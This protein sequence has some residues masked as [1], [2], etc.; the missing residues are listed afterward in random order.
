VSTKTGRVSRF[1][2]VAGVALAMA[3]T[4]GVLAAC[5]PPPSSGPSPTEKFCE[6]WDK[7]EEQQP[8]QDPTVLEDQAVLVKDEVVALADQ[9]EVLGNSCTDPTAR[10]DLDGAVLAEGTEVLEEQ[11]TASTDKVAAITGE[12]IAPGEPVLENVRLTA[13]SAEIGANG[14]VVRGNVAVQL[15]GTTSTIG[16]IGTLQSLE[17]WSVGL[18]STGFTLP[19]ITTSPVVFNG[20]LRV[21]GGVP[22]LSL[23]AQA[24]AVKIGDVSVTGASLNVQA[25]PS[26]GVQ[27]SVVGN[28]KVGP[29]TVSGTVD[30]DFD[31]NGALVSINADIAA[32]LQGTQA[33][34]KKIDL[35]GA[36]KIVGNADETAITFSG[37]G[38]L[39]DLV[40]NEANGSLVLA[41]NKATL[42]GVIDVQQ[43]PNVVR[44]NGSIVWD[45]ITAYTPFLTLQGAG[46]YSGTL[47]DGTELSVDGTLDTTVVGGQVRAV[48]E[49]NFKIGNLRASGSAIVEV[50]G[51]TTTLEV[52]AELTNAG[53]TGQLNGVVVITDGR[54]ELVDLDAAVVGSITFGDATLTGATFHVDS[55]YGNP[56]NIRFAGGLQVGTR[57]NVTADIQ[58]AIGP[59]GG[60][61]S[62]NGTV[63]G[64]LLLDSWG[65]AN[66]SGS[67]VA[68]S[69]QVTLSGTG[70]I[71][72]VNFPLGVNFNGSFTS[73]LNEPT[74]S[75]TGSGSFR[76]ASIQLASARLKLSQT[77]GMQATRAGFYFNILFIPTYLEADFYMRPEGGCSRVNLTGGSFLARPI[78]A[79]ALPGL[80]GCPVS[81]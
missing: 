22:S 25:S 51:P 33:G 39:G 66:F 74:W 30:V 41:T 15:S 44:F 70:R 27:A 21:I 9:T 24:S 81:Y 35:T 20:T 53:F 8:T 56:L 1:S 71:A 11:G 68:S 46:E 49:G 69:D 4:G 32:R 13:L 45:G 58:A 31:R 3:L 29:S 67:V 77:A 28:I 79:L 52:A 5:A 42:V 7:V 26:T 17:N 60:L 80:V 47:E 62:L 10:I 55:T 19:G 59:N 37:S 61:L 23:S 50:N 40:V 16:F 78:A 12:E 76:I 43:G 57:A 65:I 64:S 48:V 2:R 63:N 14:I 75:L 73:K 34:G 54:A 36:V 38:V 72:T 18:S 6:F